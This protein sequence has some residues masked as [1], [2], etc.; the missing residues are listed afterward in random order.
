MFALKSGG[1][2]LSVGVLFFAA[3]TMA[4]EAAACTVNAEFF[5]Q[6][7]A[8]TL[9]AC[10]EGRDGWTF[11]AG[12][13]G[14]LSTVLHLAIS[15]GAGLPVLDAIRRVAGD[16]WGDLRERVTNDGRTALHLAAMSDDPD[17]V[18]WLLYWGAEPN[19]EYGVESRWNPTAWD[20]GYT[21]LHLAAARLGGADVV[22]ALLAGG[23]N[24]EMRRPPNDTGWSAALIAS[25]HAE[26]LRTLTALAAGGADLS[27]KG[28]RNNGA[29]HVATAWD[30]SPEVIRFLLE[31]G[32]DADETNAESQTPLHLAARFASTR[33]TIEL[34]LDDADEPCVE[35]A[36]GRTAS[37]LLKSG[38]E[39][40]GQDPVLRRRFHEICI[41]GG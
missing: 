37:D 18:R 40:L 6:N 4:Y 31:S 9:I 26:D 29:L 25:R 10:L 8:D 7:E 15:S 16:E 39:V 27:R 19:P 30:R 1:A 12:R 23:A 2:K 38:N 28:E 3:S 21:P 41:E 22:S 36:E 24:P 33:E 32:L 11:L 14:D 35:D 34:L 17:Q 13:D 20:L 5:G